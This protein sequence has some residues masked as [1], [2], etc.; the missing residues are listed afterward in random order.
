MFLAASCVIIHKLF[1]DIH[2][3]IGVQSRCM[4]TMIYCSFFQTPLDQQNIPEMTVMTRQK[5]MLLLAFLMA[6]QS[7][8]VSAVIDDTTALCPQ[9]CSCYRQVSYQPCVSRSVE[10]PSPPLDNTR[11]MVIVWRLRG[12]II[13]TALCWIA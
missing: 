6:T 2:V 3:D 7:L 13:R 8:T 5:L 1:G 4:L 11:V 12:N 9:P 10:T